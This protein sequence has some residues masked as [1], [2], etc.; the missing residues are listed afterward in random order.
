MDSAFRRYLLPG[1]I[2]QSVLIGGAYGTG[3]EIVEYGARFGGDG[4]YSILAIFVGFVVTCGVTYEFA[5]VHRAYDYRRF[6]RK[7]I[8]RAWALFDL[9]FVAMAVVI[10]A[11][12]SAASGS[13]LQTTL[14]WPEW[15]GFGIVVVVV[16]ALNASGRRGIERFKTIGTGLLYSGYAIFAGLV[17]WQ[18]GGELPRALATGTA[19]GAG[20]ALTAGV[21]YVGYNLA[22]LP[23]VLFVLDE[24]TS[25]RDSWTAALI[26][27]ALGT[28]PFAATYLAIL[29]A[30]PDSTVLE[31]AVPWLELLSRHGAPWMYALFGL[32]LLWTLIETS[33]GLIHAVL[34]RVS[35]TLEEQGRSP[36]SRRAAGL[37]TVTILIAAAL[38]SRL[39]LIALVAQ[40]YRAM[41]Y[42]FLALFVL[43]LLTVGV[44]RI[45][46]RG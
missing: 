14:G 22:C 6:M 2:F 4:V 20:T 46:G 18:A 45:A 11:V 23:T 9:L 36:L 8:G 5:R 39:G 34:D 35:G 21:L 41:A 19:A 25:S 10:I 13:V 42:A 37:L 26:T 40:G 16:G 7:L 28:L 30:Y 33:T 38:L 43:P 12:V 29:T 1:I 32:V 31:A 44:W 17:L 27:G 24:Q 3:R 15:M